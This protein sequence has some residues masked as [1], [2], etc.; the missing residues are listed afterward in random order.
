MP[1]SQNTNDAPGADAAP[2][3][4]PQRK[5]LRVTSPA[6]LLAAVPVL[7]GFQPSPGTSS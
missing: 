5:Q 7:L 2:E 1:A 4:G 6:G 3:P